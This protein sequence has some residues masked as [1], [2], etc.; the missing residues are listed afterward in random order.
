MLSRQG[1]VWPDLLAGGPLLLPSRLVPRR[2]GRTARRSCYGIATA[3]NRCG[4]S[5]PARRA[6]SWSPTA[7]AARLRAELG[8][9]PCA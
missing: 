8:S 9:Q 2:V 1:E 5:C 3:A 4:C 6:M 7:A